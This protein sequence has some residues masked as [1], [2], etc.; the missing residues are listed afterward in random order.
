MD[1]EVVERAVKALA[2]LNAG[3]GSEARST[4]ALQGRHVTQAEESRGG[5]VAACG[6]PR[7][8]GCYVVDLAT[9][10]KIHPPK[11]SEEYRAWLE[12]WESKGRVQ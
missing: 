2:T 1:R 8:A 6:S 7:C 4:S 5:E 9:G 10:A 11:C 12:R 3:R